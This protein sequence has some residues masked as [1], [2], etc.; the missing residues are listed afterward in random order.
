[1]IIKRAGAAAI[2][3]IAPFFLLAAAGTASPSTA[4]SSGAT[5]VVDDDYAQ[6]ASADFSSI[7]DAVVAARPGDTVRVC[8]GL[9]R[10]R[11]EINKPLHLI[12][13]PNAV[14]SLDCF[15][16]TWTATTPLDTTVLPVLERPVSDITSETPLP[17]L[18]LDAERVE[19][20][21]LAVRSLVQPDPTDHIYTPAIQTDGTHGGYWVHGNLIQ[22]SLVAR[23][24]TLG[25]ELGSNGTALSRV[26][27]NCLR[28]NSW[29]V[30]NQRYTT[31]LVRIDHNDTFRQG[32]L[33]Y[34]IGWSP[35][36]ISDV[37][38]DHNRSVTDGLSTVTIENAKS[39]LVD[40][41]SAEGA[42]S[43]TVVVRGGNAG[44]VI[45]DNE[46]L[47]GGAAGIAMAGALGGPLANPSTKV[48]LDRNTIQGHTNGILLSN[49]ANTS[50][51][52]ITGNILRTNR[53]V[54]IHI[55]P[56]NT[57][58]LVTGNV[59]DANPYGI[60]TGAPSQTTPDVRVRGNVIVENSMHDNGIDAL[61]STVNPDGTLGNTWT[62]NSCV[63]D[64]PAEAI[65]TT[66]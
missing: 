4:V 53:L 58:A 59:S 30:A 5:L 6:C 54:G 45:R 43:P 64:V 41:N 60:R 15:D 1:M 39:V 28:G 32:F 62:H 27:H 40:H 50:D 9:Y 22:G 21:G 51:M 57:G 11:V 35:A 44:V 37:R 63:T 10:E 65:C 12:G 49:N 13:Q 29:A 7:M 18:R 26:D 2:S 33:A 8:P 34:E 38:L 17:L 36:G 55:G 66:D 14:D 42:T 19:V 47:A 23:D 20:A 16:P 31:S 46:L 56:T 24:W 25:I 3:A 48:V 61:E 52:V